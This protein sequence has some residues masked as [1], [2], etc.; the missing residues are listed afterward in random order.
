MTK[1]C[2]WCN[3]EK[4]E[5]DIYGYQEDEDNAGN[6]IPRYICTECYLYTFAG[7][8]TSLVAETTTHGDGKQ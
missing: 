1:K 7:G 6:I 4:N 3:Q 8:D 2:E 5:K